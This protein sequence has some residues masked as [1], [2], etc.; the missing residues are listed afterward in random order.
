MWTQ[1]VGKIRLVAMPWQNHS[2][3]TSLYITTHGLST[4][5]IPYGNGIF[6]INFDFV[7][8]KLNI[9]STF[10]KTVEIDLYPRSVADFYKTI[11]ESLES[12]GIMISIYPRPNELPDNTPFYENEEDKSYDKEAMT[13]YWQIAVHVHNIFSYFRSGFIGK[14]SPIHFF[15]GAFDI[16]LTRFSG[17]IAPE[18]P[19]IAPHMPG[20]VMKEAYSQEVSSVG[21]WPGSDDFPEPVFYSYCY[22]TPKDFGA[23]KVL[24]EQAFYSEDMGEYFLPYKA[25]RSSS[26]PNA[27]LL[28]FLKTTYEAAANTGNWDRLALERPE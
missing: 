11:F 3:H 18:H 27:T 10:E 1:I 12:V 9:S 6:E 2:W 25:V 26:N 8:H 22:P 28:C 4:G 7:N 16:A 5:S 24:P 15:W 14:C 17:R 23:Q 21:F 13:D 19:G 20:D